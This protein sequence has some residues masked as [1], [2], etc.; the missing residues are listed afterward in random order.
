MT[1]PDGVRKTVHKVF[2]LYMGNNNDNTINGGIGMD[3]INGFGGNDILSGG[4]G[5]DSLD[6][7][8]GNDTLT[9]RKWVGHLLC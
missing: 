2:T 6:G 4:D 8:S 3:D 1:L 9:G 7:M 5:D